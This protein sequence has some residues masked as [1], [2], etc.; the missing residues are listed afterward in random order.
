MA[1]AAVELGRLA[2]DPDGP[3]VPGPSPDDTALVLS[4][5]AALLAAHGGLFGL[6]LDGTG[7]SPGRWN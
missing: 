6:S 1:R 5:A 7:M 4:D 3:H 2:L